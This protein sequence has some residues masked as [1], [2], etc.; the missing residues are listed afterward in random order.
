MSSRPVE[1]LKGI[2]QLGKI[3]LSEPHPQENHVDREEGCKDSDNLVVVL[4]DDVVQGKHN[5]THSPSVRVRI[6][7]GALEETTFAPGENHRCL[8]DAC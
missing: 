5:F 4:W 1:L 3:I 8:L 6:P 7:V 2:L